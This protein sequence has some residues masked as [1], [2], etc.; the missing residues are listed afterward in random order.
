MGRSAILGELRNNDF[1]DVCCGSGVL[2]DYSYAITK[3]GILCEFN[4][5]RLLDRWI[6]LK[7]NTISILKKNYLYLIVSLFNWIYFLD[8]LC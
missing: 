4:S 1:I 8:N 7:V 5:R 2:K 3:S 6:E